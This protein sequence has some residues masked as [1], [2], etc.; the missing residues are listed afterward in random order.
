MSTQIHSWLLSSTWE[1]LIVL[2]AAI[3]ERGCDLSDPGT[4]LLS[5]A[6]VKLLRGTKSGCLACR[7]ALT[8]LHVG[9]TMGKYGTV[10]QRRLEEEI[11]TE[12]SRETERGILREWIIA[13]R[14]RR[15]DGPKQSK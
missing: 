13:E 11:Q 9:N 10:W 3:P 1:S 7:V 8:M 2:H 12:L 14:V 6:P 15:Q 4:G 5:T